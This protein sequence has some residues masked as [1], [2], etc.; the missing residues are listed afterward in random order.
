MFQGRKTQTK[1]ASKQ[2]KTKQV[3]SLLLET[4][5]GEHT[6]KQFEILSALRL[7]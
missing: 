5:V 6:E 7:K 1:Q 4:Q 3:R 2:N